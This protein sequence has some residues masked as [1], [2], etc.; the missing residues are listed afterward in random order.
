MP[1]SM[2]EEDLFKTLVKRKPEAQKPYIAQSTQRKEALRTVPAAQPAETYEKKEP[3]IE[4]P[5]V[6]P[7]ETELIVEAVKNLTTSVNMIY[8]LIKTVILPVLVFILVVGIAIL[9]RLK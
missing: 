7:L 1:S 2:S 6:K 3:V 4:T 8:G 9:V 5:P